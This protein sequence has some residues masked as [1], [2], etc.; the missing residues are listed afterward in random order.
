LDEREIN[1][2]PGGR[3]CC[4][5]D[6]VSKFHGIVEPAISLLVNNDVGGGYLDRGKGRV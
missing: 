6:S 5:V 4:N 1:V 2:P 3:I